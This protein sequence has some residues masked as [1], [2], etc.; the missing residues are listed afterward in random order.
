MSTFR[1]IC[2][3]HNMD[4]FC[5]WCFSGIFLMYFMNNLETVLM[6]SAITGVTFVLTFHVH[7]VC[8]VRSSYF[9]TECYWLFSWSYFFLLKLK[10]IL[11][12][13]FFL[14][15]LLLLLLLLLWLGLMVVM[16]KQQ[17]AIRPYLEPVHFRHTFISG[18]PHLYATNFLLNKNKVLRSCLTLFLQSPLSS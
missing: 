6:A 16:N 11:T 3:A 18:I 7:C 1:N 4:V 10:Y 12:Y 14:H 13:M 15:Y 5:S 9:T 17:H 8:I 2:A